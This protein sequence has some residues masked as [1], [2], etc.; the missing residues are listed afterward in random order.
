MAHCSN[1]QIVLNSIEELRVKRKRRDHETVISHAEKNHGPS[2]SDGR[3]SLCY[4]MNKGFVINKPTQ[5]GHI[6]LFVKNNEVDSS[7]TTSDVVDKLI[8]PSPS[9]PGNL[10][11]GESQCKRDD[12]EVHEDRQME[13]STLPPSFMSEIGITNRETET[14]SGEAVNL[15][16]FGDDTLDELDLGLGTFDT[17]QKHPSEIDNLENS[18]FG[19]FLGIIVKL[20]DDIR[21]LNFMLSEE[22][23]TADALRRENFLLQM[24]TSKQK[25]NNCTSEVYKK[26]NSP[27]ETLPASSASAHCQEKPTVPPTEQNPPLNFEQRWKICLEERRK[28]F[29]SYQVEHKRKQQTAKQQAKVKPLG[30][31]RQ[32][33]NK[34]DKQETKDSNDHNKRNETRKVPNK[35]DAIDPL[36]KTTPTTTTTPALKEYNNLQ[37]SSTLGLKGLC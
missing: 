10:F 17:P 26:E 4:L 16:N 34:Q 13:D 35:K 19:A 2:V 12:S 3:E 15:S 21:E 33:R 31:D 23:K 25:K 11:D 27:P 14:K 5:A 36:V 9:A 6:S 20:T 22:R 7:K 24:E 18:D 30:K 1:S 28:K 37:I 32:G 8:D 29:E